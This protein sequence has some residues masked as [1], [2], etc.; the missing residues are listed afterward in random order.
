MLANVSQVSVN[1]FDQLLTFNLSSLPVVNGTI[2]FRIYFYAATLDQTDWDDLVSS[3]AGG[4][5]LRLFAASST[6]LD[7]TASD[8]CAGLILV[9]DY[10]NSSTLVGANFP[11]GTTTVV[12]TATDACGNTNSCS[13]D[14]TVG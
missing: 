14:V 2:T 1:P 10:N 12:W 3:A 6:S 13:F 5:G 11:I 8:A 9:N 7:A 4:T